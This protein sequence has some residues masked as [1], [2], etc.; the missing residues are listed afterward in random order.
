MP[1]RVCGQLMVV[2][3]PVEGP[4][5]KHYVKG[6][7]ESNGVW[8]KP[9]QDT[10]LCSYHSRKEEGWFDRT[11]EYWHTQGPRPHEFVRYESYWTQGG[12]FISARPVRGKSR[13][14]LEG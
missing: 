13:S 14:V 5:Y 12:H 10:D 4:S 8:L 2:R 1:C 11:D 9:M 6:Q 7:H 3:K